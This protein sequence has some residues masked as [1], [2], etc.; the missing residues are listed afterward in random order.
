MFF[1]TADE[2]AAWLGKH[3]AGRSELIIGYCKR[4]TRRPSLI[5]PESVDAALCRA[6][7]ATVRYA[8]RGM[9]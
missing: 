4:A 3:G 2:F 1:E 9:V 5:W 8:A 6:L 7:P